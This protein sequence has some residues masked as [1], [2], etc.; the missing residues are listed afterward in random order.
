MAE[1]FAV[2]SEADAV[3]VWSLL[4]DKI[5]EAVWQRVGLEKVQGFVRQWAG[6]WNQQQESRQQAQDDW[7]RKAKQ[8]IEAAS[9]RYEKQGEGFVVSPFPLEPA[10]GSTLPEVRMVG[11]PYPPDLEW[12]IP[13][14]HRKYDVPEQWAVMAAIHDYYYPGEQISPWPREQFEQRLE[15]RNDLEQDSEEAKKLIVE[16]V[17]GF[18]YWRHVA[19]VDRLTE[20]NKPVIESWLKEVA[21]PPA[22]S[23]AGSATAEPRA[24]QAMNPPETITESPTAAVIGK[25]VS[26]LDAALILTEEDRPLAMEKKTAWQKLRTPKVPRSIGNCPNHKQVKL[27]APSALNIFVEEVEG[28]SLCTQYRL[29]QRLVAK[30]R[31]PRQQ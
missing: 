6:D 26:L 17:E 9:K 27:F 1:F 23:A 20:Y 22:P 2:A 3:A 28:K 16:D 31:E 13:L 8:L 25:G 18:Y 15:D 11:V 10:P 24:A 5:H 14:L 30:A 7:R 19:R 4:A 12:L 21:P 29:R